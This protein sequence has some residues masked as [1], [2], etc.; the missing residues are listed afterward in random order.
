MLLFIAL[1]LCILGWSL[2][3]NPKHSGREAL[4]VLAIAAFTCMFGMYS[5]T[6]IGGSGMKLANVA[7]STFFCILVCPPRPPA[8]NSPSSPRLSSHLRPPCRFTP[9]SQSL[10]TLLSFHALRVPQVGIVFCGA[11]AIGR[12]RSLKTYKNLGGNV[13][14]LIGI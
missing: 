9:S 7:M 2:D 14:L 5:V 3:S 6:S 1:F 8:A 12:E 10:H 13:R 11:A 4:R